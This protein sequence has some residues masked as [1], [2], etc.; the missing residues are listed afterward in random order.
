MIK[1]LNIIYL[2]KKM[3]RILFGK[4]IMV[5]FLIKT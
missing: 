5:L 3:Y 1:I 4:D 2:L